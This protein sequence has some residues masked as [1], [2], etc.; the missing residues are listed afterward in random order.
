MNMPFRTRERFGL[1][2]FR[3]IPRIYIYIYEDSIPYFHLYFCISKEVHG[4]SQWPRG[5]RHELSLPDPTLKS[6]IRIPREEW[7]FVFVCPL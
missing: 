1:K 4:R 3:T 6:W 5:L 2:D 7:M